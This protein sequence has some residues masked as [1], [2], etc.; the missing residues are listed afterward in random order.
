MKRKRGLLT[1]L[2]MAALIVFAAFNTAANCKKEPVET[3]HECKFEQAWTYDGSEHWHK[4]VGEGAPHATK[5]RIK[6][7]TSGTAAL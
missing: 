7:R 3:Q 2:T 1:V 4:C 6:P 5:C